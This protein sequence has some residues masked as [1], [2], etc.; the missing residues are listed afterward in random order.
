MS[1]R[2][3]SNSWLFFW[4]GVSLLLPRLEYNG[5]ISAHRNLRLL[6]SGN[7]PASASCVA[8][9]TGTRHH[10]KL[11]FCIFNRDGVST[12]WPGWSRSVDLVIHPP[13][14]PKV[15]GLQAWAIPPGHKLQ[16]LNDTPTS[17]SQSVGIT[18]VSHCAQPEFITCLSRNDKVFGVPVFEMLWLVG[19][20]DNQT[21]IARSYWGDRPIFKITLDVRYYMALYS[22]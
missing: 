15:L 11:I 14:P 22:C 13:W 17:A 4:D 19:G 10:A 18:G 20:G 8:G 21:Q 12:C 6:G 16:T 2:L 1:V 7:S 3:V 5:V 9:I